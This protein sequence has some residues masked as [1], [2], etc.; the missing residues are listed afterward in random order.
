MTTFDHHPTLTNI[1]IFTSSFS[2]LK[3]GA[4]SSSSMELHVLSIPEFPKRSFGPDSSGRFI[5]LHL[6]LNNH[7][8]LFAIAAAHALPTQPMEPK[9]HPVS[10]R[11]FSSIPFR[12]PLP[13]PMTNSFP[14]PVLKG[15][16]YVSP[17]RSFA[18]RSAGLGTSPFLTKSTVAPEQPRT[19]NAF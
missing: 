4:C 17:G 8:Q 2:W 6:L 3:L 14:S 13:K 18:L 19:S 15:R 12:D 10:G 11:S 5:A 7:S 16:Q 9:R 1:R